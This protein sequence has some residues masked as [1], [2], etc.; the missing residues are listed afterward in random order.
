MLLALLPAISA[1]FDQSSHEM[2]EK[3]RVKVAEQLARSRNYTCVQTIDRSYFQSAFR[4]RSA[5][6]VVSPNDQD[7][8]MHDRLR[9]NVAVSD[10]GEIYSWQGD[11]KFSSTP[12][13]KIVQ[14]G[15]IS[16]GS[17]VGFLGNI[18][19]RPGIEFIYRGST[20]KGSVEA[21]HFDYRVRRAV[22]RFR[23]EGEGNRSA[24][25]PFHGSFTANAGS[26][27]LIQL[28]ILA[29]QI[30]SDLAICATDNEV[31]Y[32]LAEISGNLTLIP[33]TFELRVNADHH[34]DT[35]SRST[36]SQCHEFQAVS[37][38]HFD[39]PG[40]SKQVTG[41]ADI[42][43][44]LPGGLTLPLALTS[45]IDAK[46]AYTGAPVEAVTTGPVRDAQGKTLIPQG[47]GL[48]GIITQLERFYRPQTTTP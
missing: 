40:E 2:L 30:P 20:D 38:L 22:S 37:T 27:E 4:T 3:I 21:V 47:T 36:Y 19:I 31:Q 48:H 15:P 44:W 14:G 8:I 17:F 46:T 16:S 23:V 24:I 33:R 28:R 41:K 25:V 45:R 32:Q 7:E 12:V 35:V 34:F 29:D 1:A 26:F 6:G 43:Q 11:R 10:G 9:L 18:F 42:E 5:C 39:A 13:D